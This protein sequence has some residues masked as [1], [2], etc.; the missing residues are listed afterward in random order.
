MLFED[1]CAFFLDRL[2]NG[3]GVV[4]ALQ[5]HASDDIELTGQGDIETLNISLCGKA[6]YD[7]G[8]FDHAKAEV[9]SY[10]NKPV[11]YEILKP[12]PGFGKGGIASRFREDFF[13]Q[14]SGFSFYEEPTS[15][16]GYA[17]IFGVG[18]GFHLNYLAQYLP[19]KVFVFNECDFDILR[20]NW[21]IFP[22]REFV[23]SLENRGI[24]VVFNFYEKPGFGG[25]GT[26][27]IMRDE[28]HVFLDGSYLYQHGI[29][30]KGVN[31]T[32]FDEFAKARNT[33]EYSM[34]FFEDEFLMI[35]NA[36]ANLMTYDFHLMPAKA[37][38][39]WGVPAVV[40]GSGPSVDNSMVSAAF[41]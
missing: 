31:Q 20:K 22:W 10:L 17:V 19:V 1:N 37:D 24:K 23:H 15:Q 38:M 39:D 18:L 41:T 16:G 3:K 26:M 25:A 7:G 6:L 2:Q 40:V 36:M 14:L 5:N 12:S 30:P 35:K 11:R 4:S 13:S 32:C 29:D 9:T 28:N 21:E 8:A 27:S 33:L 34:G